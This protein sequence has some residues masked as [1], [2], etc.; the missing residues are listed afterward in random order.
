MNYYGENSSFD[1]SKMLQGKQFR[2]QR[3]INDTSKNGHLVTQ[4]DEIRIIQMC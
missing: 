4:L 2:H 1:S 3:C